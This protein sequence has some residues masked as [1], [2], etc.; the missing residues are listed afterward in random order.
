ML[1]FAKFVGANTDFATAQSF[2]FPRILPE[3]GS[4]PVFGLVISCEG[5][6]VFAYVKGKILNLEEKFSTVFDSVTE[7]LHELGGILKLEFKEVE[8]LKFSLFLVK[9]NVF[10]IFQFGN[11]IIELDREGKLTSV[12]SD[13]SLQEK[14]ISGFLQPGDRILIL[15]SKSGEINWRE[16]VVEQVLQLPLG[17]V[18][19][20]EMI[21]AQDELKMEKQQDLA[22]VKNI[23]PVAFILIENELA[24]E[25]S[26]LE[27]VPQIPKPRINFKVKL[28]QFNIWLFFHRFSRQFF[29]LIRRM[30]RKVILGLG[31]LIL[32]LIVGGGSFLF[33]QN[34]NSQRN[35]RFNNLIGSIENDL[36]E[37]LSLKDTD[38]KQASEKI[39][40][41]KSKLNEVEGLDKDSPRLKELKAKIEEKEAQVLRIYKNFGLELFMSLELIKQSFQTQ[42][43]SFSVGKIL[44]LD[45]SEKSLVSIDTRLKTPDILA[46][47]QQLGEAK[48]ASI[49]GSHAFAYSPDKGI[50]HIDIDTN[51][52]SIVSKPDE[53]WGSIQ[54]IFGFGSNIYALDSGNPP[55]GGMIWKYSPTLSGYSDKQQY[56]R[57]EVNLNLG[58]RLVIDYSVWVLTSEPD[59]VKFTAGNKDFY[60]LSGL[61]EPLTQI[62][63]IFVTEDLDSVFILD[64][65]K[66]RILATKKNGEYLAQYL[67]DNFRKV[68]DF[69][70][71]EESKFIYLLI[72]NKIFKTPLR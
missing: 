47:S 1:K 11:N 33:W 15:S 4:E 58:K 3:E 37:A 48:L 43:M 55:A 64:K 63:G 13:S 49:N 42:R 12:I 61:N 68:D 2:L 45:T 30:N 21:F 46:G 71:D 53:S 54:D 32:V 36:N 24:K 9:S 51:K 67:N 31:V 28:P 34:R 60:A 44:L 41:A 8:N 29:G 69:F 38:S 56:L 65:S 25:A 18:D 57:S 27:T 35:V 7:K 62:D 26:T 20:V 23:E 59:I 19:D 5:E 70:V 52:A 50:V 39:T 40:Q 72:E 17:A 14:V 16:E 10:Y 66:N 22:G 6:D